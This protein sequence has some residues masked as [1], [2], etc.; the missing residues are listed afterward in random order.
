M[1]ALVTNMSYDGNSRLITTVAERRL[2][3]SQKAFL[4]SSRH[5]HCTVNVVLSNNLRWSAK[6]WQAVRMSTN[7]VQVGSQ[8]LYS[9]CC[10]HDQC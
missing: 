3:I 1:V 2:E 4:D 9:R 7:A 10:D 5:H 8:V 6:R